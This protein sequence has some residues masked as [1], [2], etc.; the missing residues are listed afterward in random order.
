[1]KMEINE[2]DRNVILD[3]FFN[4]MRNLEMI[5]NHFKGKYT[6]REIKNVTRERIKG[7]NGNTRKTTK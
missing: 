4:K 6:Y 7:C 2:E 5:E 1:M 3:L